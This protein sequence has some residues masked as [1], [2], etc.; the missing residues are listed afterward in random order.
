MVMIE[1]FYILDICTNP[2]F[3][4]VIL[5]G[6]IILEYVFILVP[7]GL[8]IMLMIDFAKNV[9][10][11]NEENIKKNYSLALKRLI[12]CVCLFSVPTIVSFVIGVVEDSISGLN[13]NYQSC[14]KNVDNIEYYQE[15]ADLEKEKEENEKQQQNE[16][17][18][19]NNAILNNSNPDANSSNDYIP[20]KKYTLTDSQ[21]RGLAKVCQN[22]QGTVLGAKAEAS[23]MANRFELFGSNY[24]TDGDGL[25]NY[26]A[27]SGWFANSKSTIYDT[28]NLRSEILSA[29]KEVLVLGNRTLALYVDEHDCIDCGRYGFDVVKIVNNDKIITDS[30]GLKNHNNYKKNNTIIYNRYGSVY[31]FYTFPTSSSDPFGYTSYAKNKF[32]KINGVR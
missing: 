9:V 17:N 13:V 12:F 11:N 31:T 7:I 16:V 24:G 27:N 15:L 20:G 29:V 19:E 30:E 18:R 6:K 5:F 14:L 22:E 21:L 25:F 26:V 32:D 10:T 4:K 23:L 2:D 3:L 28:S 8:V 1:L